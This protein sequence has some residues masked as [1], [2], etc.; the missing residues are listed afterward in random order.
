MDEI[1]KEEIL[2]QIENENFNTMKYL[3][4]EYLSFKNILKMV[5]KYLD[6]VNYEAA[7]DICKFL[8]KSKSYAKFLKNMDE[9]NYSFNENEIKILEDLEGMLPIKRVHEF[10]NIKFLIDN[11]S[12]N[13][14]QS[15]SE[16]LKYVQHTEKETVEHSFKYL[17]WEFLDDGE[18]KR[19]RKLFN[20]SENILRKTEEFEK[21]LK[22]ET[23]KEYL[24]DMLMFG[25]LDYEK[26]FG[27]EDYG[28]PFLKLYENYS[29]RDIALLS[30]YGKMH[31]SY[32]NGVNPSEDK[33]NYY[34]FINLN[35]EDTSI[36]ENTIYDR[37]HF[38][39]YSKSSTKADSETGK[40]FIYNKERNVKLHFFVRKF[41]KIDNI[42][43]PF[44]YLGTGSPVEHHGE[45]PI[46]FKIRLDDK[47]EN[48]TYL[49]LITLTHP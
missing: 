14:S 35:K 28:T 23:F 45:Q 10:T 13:I 39:W 11:L 20:L 6:Y 16:V 8:I 12:L 22:N 40:D 41:S 7:P 26:K 36:F 47:I 1:A 3:K 18:K 43:Q 27:N 49:D 48:S 33:K 37:R 17:N 15:E 19:K 29:M 21:A 2:K 30:N 31:S 24:K 42:T 5:P 25:I 32:R 4:E 38:K 9:K 44:V 46:Q 34:M